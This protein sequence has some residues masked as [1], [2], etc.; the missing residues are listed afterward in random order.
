MMKAIWKIIPVLL[1]TL[2]GVLM[3]K[4]S[5]FLM[6]LVFELL[7]IALLLFYIRILKGNISA[8]W[9]LLNPL[10]NKG[11]EVPILLDVANRS[12]FPVS[13]ILV[14]LVVDSVYK[15]EPQVIERVGSLPSKEVSRFQF[16]EASRYAGWRSYSIRSIT[17][18]DLMHLFSFSI[19]CEDVISVT[20]LPDLIPTFVQ[21]QD[22]TRYYTNE[23][24]SSPDRTG[25]DIS[26]ISKIR[27]FQNGDT[28]QRI[29]WKISAKEGVLMTREFGSS[30][31]CAVLFLLNLYG[32]PEKKT[33]KRMDAFWDIT[34]S[35]CA[36]MI[37]E[38]CPLNIVWYDE[39]EQILRNMKIEKE[40]DGYEFLVEVLKARPYT[41]DYPLEEL[42]RAKYPRED[43][44]V[45]LQLNTDLTLMKDYEKI[46]SFT[47]EEH[48]KELETLCVEI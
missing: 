32:A 38:Q 26:E 42:Y 29:H 21:I 6:L 45:T 22:K 40:Q 10:V 3:V 16:G 15:K 48:K 46:A 9:R 7:W 44:V 33:A 28:L 11:E 34:W 39:E 13:K 8:R 37:A 2:F 5:F 12:S 24:D 35:L 31:G 1:F 19:P 30:T 18:F 43:S 14:E 27:E 23:E 36:A 25:D 41:E 20:V 4:G 47:E 17:V